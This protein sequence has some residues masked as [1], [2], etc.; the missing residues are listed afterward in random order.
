MATRIF[1]TRDLARLRIAQGDLEQAL[2]L[3]RQ[4]HDMALAGFPP[5]DPV[6]IGT[7]HELA[8]ALW[9]TGQDDEQARQLFTECLD[10]SRRVLGP[11]HE[12]TISTATALGNVLR[13]LGN[14]EEGKPLLEDSYAHYRKELGEDHPS[15]TNT[16]NNLAFTYQ[17]LEEHDQALEMFTRSLAN[18]RRVYGDESLKTV[19]GLNNIGLQLGLM[20]RPDD[21][22][23]Y[24]EE[25]KR[26]AGSVL[27]EEHWTYWAVRAT[28][29]GTLLRVGDHDAAESELLASFNGMKSILGADHG[30]TRGV[31]KTLALLYD[32][33]GDGER[34]TE[35]RALA[36]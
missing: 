15:T 20:D 30:R 28:Y 8:V 29:G 35:Y 12:E 26:L 33:M 21:A 9:E 6:S 16:L 17:Q 11:N 18:R 10:L 13:A 24:L 3:A 31:A 23:P 32:A 34:A 4:A 19:I 36:P 25:A 22:L 27:G 14:L 5:E 2:A 1:F 7:L